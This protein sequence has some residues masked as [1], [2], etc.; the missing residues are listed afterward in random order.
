MLMDPDDIRR[1]L[2]TQ[3]ARD[4]FNKVAALGPKWDV[5]TT[6]G[7]TLLPDLAVCYGETM[8]LEECWGEGATFDA[9][10]EATSARLKDLMTRLAANPP[11]QAFTDGISVIANPGLPQ[12][13]DAFAYDT[14][15]DTFTPRPMP[16]QKL[17]VRR[18]DTCCGG[19]CGGC[20]VYKP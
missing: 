11:R 6:R 13:G 5:N 19:D 10:A 17:Y 2:T 8:L 3:S 7:V 20:P 16:T 18:L 12:T 1:Q 15:T 4:A 9:A 14:A